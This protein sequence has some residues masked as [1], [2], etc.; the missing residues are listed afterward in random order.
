MSENFQFLFSGSIYRQEREM[1]AN[2]V[3]DF[4]KKIISRWCAV[5]PSGHCF[6]SNLPARAQAHQKQYFLECYN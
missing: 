4:K 5:R 2:T 3:I 1:T 6:A